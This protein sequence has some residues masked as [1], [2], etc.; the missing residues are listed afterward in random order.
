[1]FFKLNVVEHSEDPYR[2]NVTCYQ[3]SI[4]VTRAR[5]TWF[6]WPF[7][8]LTLT[9]QFQIRPAAANALQP[10]DRPHST[11]FPFLRRRGGREGLGL[12]VK[13]RD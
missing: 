4:S 6:C 13:R 11:P 9:S 8:R 12:G 7:S 10:S 3:S 2:N 5:A 1:M